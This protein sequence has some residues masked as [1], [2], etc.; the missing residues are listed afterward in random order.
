MAEANVVLL[1]PALEPD[2]RLV[3]LIRQLHAAGFKDIFVIDD[4]SGA[5]F[6]D[7][8]QEAEAAGDVCKRGNRCMAVPLSAAGSCSKIYSGYVVVFS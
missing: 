5:A 8:F 6:A 2:K 1:I 3:G 7:I 4:G